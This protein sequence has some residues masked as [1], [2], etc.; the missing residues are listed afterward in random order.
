MASTSR[1]FQVNPLGVLSD[2]DKYINDHVQANLLARTREIEKWKYGRTVETV[3]GAESFDKVQTTPTTTACTPASLVIAVPAVISSP[4]STHQPSTFH[5]R[6]AYY[7]ET[8]D[9]EFI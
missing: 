7:I 4:P 2:K 8:K 1:N 6:Q 5:S 9:V 3:W